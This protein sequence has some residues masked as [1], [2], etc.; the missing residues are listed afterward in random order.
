MKL[1]D[2]SYN[3]IHFNPEEDIYRICLG[4]C[5]CYN[6][7]VPK[8]YEEQCKFVEKHRK[9]GSPLEHSSLSVLFN[10]NRGISHELVRHRHTSYSQES[11]RYCNYSHN[12]FGNEITFI[13]DTQV[14]S[15]VVDYDIW[16]NELEQLESIYLKR[17]HFGAP[18]EQA[19]GL[20]PNDVATKLLVTTNYREWIDI[21]NLRCDRNAH[22]QMRE[23]MKPLYEELYNKLPCVF[24]KVEYK[25][26]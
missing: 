9:H 13:N 2:A 25:T 16:I 12:R 21:F 18:A 7:P 22:Y 3:I 17:L 10:I 14:I 15:N 5:L 20:L 24:G 6:T 8:T 26:S 4:Y 11:T 1:I 19:R 23:I